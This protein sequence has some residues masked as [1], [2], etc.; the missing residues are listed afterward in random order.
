MVP[1]M[2]GRD[3][4]RRQAKTLRKMVKVAQDPVVADRLC[5]MAEDFEMRASVRSD[6]FERQ[7]RAAGTRV[8]GDDGHG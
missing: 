4:F 8:R 7:L 3:Y 6:E 1:V 2:I 5:E